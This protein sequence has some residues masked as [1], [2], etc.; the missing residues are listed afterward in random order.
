M[1][2]DFVIETRNLHHIY[3]GNVH[4]LKGIS[5]GIRR[6]ELLA[7]IGENGSGK[8]TL[9]KH[10]NGLLKPTDG[11]VIVNGINTQK[12]S[13]YEL[14]RHV[15][16]VFQNPKDQIFSSKVRTEVEFGPKNLKYPP[17]KV[18]ELTDKALEITG[19]SDKADVHP[20]ELLHVEQKFLCIASILAMDPD[21]VILDEPSSGMDFNALNR[22]IRIIRDL[23]NSGKTIILVSHNMDLVGQLAERT[24]VLFDGKVLLDGPTKKILQMEEQLRKTGVWP[25]QITR[26][27][28]R[29]K[30]RFN[31]FETD[32]AVVDDFVEK[33]AS[34]IEKK[35]KGG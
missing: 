8:T 3:P 12:V 32:V 4:A 19:L 21:V 27:A 26:I 16:Y 28:L 7:I 35:K 29:L 25:P 6:G 5:L 14:V 1:S 22:L 15:G 34:Y 31:D 2:E 20:Y 9:V 13:T 10:F 23:S 18:K 30:D 33:V 24:V 17:D 11:V